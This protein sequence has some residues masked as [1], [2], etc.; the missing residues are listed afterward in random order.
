MYYVEVITVF[1]KAQL[2]VFYGPFLSEKERDEY[3]EI[4]KKKELACFENNQS[5]QK[6][7]TSGIDA[8]VTEI[9]NPSHYKHIPYKGPLPPGNWEKKITGDE[10]IFC[11]VKNGDTMKFL[12][13]VLE[14]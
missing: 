9:T 2:Q 8:R 6:D 3:A 13:V 10:G 11:W 5:L 7:P 14:Q 12:Q 4:Q 1:G